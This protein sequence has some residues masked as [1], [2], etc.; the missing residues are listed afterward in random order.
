MNA[1]EPD[2]ITAN[3]REL[4]AAVGE[5][6]AALDCLAKGEAAA[7]AESAAAEPGLAPPSAIEALCSAFGLSRFERA[8]LLMCAG[9]ELDGRFA[10]LC[11][12]AQRDPVRT[13][14]TF[15]LALAAL[16]EPHWSALTPAAPLRRWRLIEFDGQPS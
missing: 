5:I 11:A 1:P 16:P 8:I 4:T 10:G 14:P 9:V 6:G 2:W 7:A 13:F 15:G 3:Q 12:A